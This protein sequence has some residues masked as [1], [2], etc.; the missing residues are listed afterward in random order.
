VRGRN[1]LIPYCLI[2]GQFLRA[3]DSFKPT[4]SDPDEKEESSFG[5]LI[6]M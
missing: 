6:S 1:Y 4:V 2:V 5:E 3:L